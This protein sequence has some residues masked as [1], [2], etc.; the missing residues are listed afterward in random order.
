MFVDFCNVEINECLYSVVIVF[1]HSVRT[2]KIFKAFK[3][4]EKFRVIQQ[5]EM[6]A[7]Q[8][9][10]SFNIMCCFNLDH[11]GFFIKQLY[12]PMGISVIRKKILPDKCKPAITLE[13]I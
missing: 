1:L 10:H 11:G 8:V 4:F 13:E 9:M 7:Q 2:K 5:I 6:C 3:G 12:P